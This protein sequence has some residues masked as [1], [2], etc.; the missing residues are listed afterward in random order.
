MG[1]GFVG[2][3]YIGNG[4]RVSLTRISPASRSCYLAYL[5]PI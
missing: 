4:A 5:L 2:A 3:D 1:G